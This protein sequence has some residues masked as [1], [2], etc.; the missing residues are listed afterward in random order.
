MERIGQLSFEIGAA[1]F[2]MAIR[3]KCGG[4]FK[5]TRGNEVKIVKKKYFL[6]F[7]HSKSMN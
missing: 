6:Q 5:C 4:K 1:I 2:D 3:T 7:K